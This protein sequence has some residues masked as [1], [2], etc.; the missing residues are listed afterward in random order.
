MIYLEALVFELDM[1]IL[2]QFMKILK[3]KDGKK[4]SWKTAL[5]LSPVKPFKN[6]FL[7]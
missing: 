5:A 3:K 1:A 4:E 2:F 7:Y 6:V